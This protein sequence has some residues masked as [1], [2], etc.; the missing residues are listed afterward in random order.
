VQNGPT[1]GFLS[2]SHMLHTKLLNLDAPFD[3]MLCHHQFPQKLL[4]PSFEVKLRRKPVD[5]SVGWFFED[6][7]P[8]HHEY[9]TTCVSLMSWTCAPLVPDHAGNTV[10]SATSSRECM[11]QVSATT[12]S[13]PATLV[14][15]SC[16]SARP[17][18][19]S[20]H[21]HEPA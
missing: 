12:A 6:Q 15:Q 4:P 3:V 20:I 10:R 21:R 1:P 2:D 7:P 16:L 9:H 11:S 18:P 19:L 13:H 5:R 14:P 17:S 8:N